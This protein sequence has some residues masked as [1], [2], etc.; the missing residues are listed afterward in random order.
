MFEAALA[1]SKEILAMMCDLAPAI[2]KE[3][4]AMHLAPLTSD[5]TQMHHL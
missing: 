1:L 3:I 4:L 2:S 5:N